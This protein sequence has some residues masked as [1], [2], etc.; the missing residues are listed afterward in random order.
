MFFARVVALV[1]TILWMWP[2]SLH[3]QSDALMEAYNQGK[4]LREAGRYEQAIPHMRK[5]LELGEKEF[6]PDHPATATLLNNLAA[7]YRDQ[8]RYK[9]AEPLFKRALAIHEKGLG[10]DHPNVAV[11]HI[12][13]MVRTSATAKLK[14]RNNFF[15]PLLPLIPR[16][17]PAKELPM[18]HM[19]DGIPPIE[20]TIGHGIYTVLS[21]CTTYQHHRARRPQGLVL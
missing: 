15:V 2:T 5:A 18:I 6:G 9:A 10:P 16:H 19:I 3:A 12:H 21:L 17:A 4:A 11:G 7:L 20:P 1:L 8:G 13:R 14:P